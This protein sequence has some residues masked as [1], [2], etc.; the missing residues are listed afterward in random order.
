MRVPTIAVNIDVNMPR[1]RVTANPLIVPV[2]NPNNTIAA[3]NVVIF[4]SAIVEN[5]FEY[6]ASILARG[7]LPDRN[8]SRIRS[9]IST[10]ASTAIPTVKTI[11]AIPGM[12]SVACNMDNKATINTRL[13]AKARLATAPNTRYQI[14]MNTRTSAKPIITEAKP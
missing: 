10:L 11:P 3:I 2:P 7:L 13:A 1:E 4:A 6:P 5:A 14:I 8:S 9:K 12:V